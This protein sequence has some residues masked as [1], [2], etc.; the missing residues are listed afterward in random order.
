MGEILDSFVKILKETRLDKDPMGALL[1]E[2]ATYYSDDPHF[3]FLVERC[4]FL[5]ERFMTE[6]PLCTC[7]DCQTD[8][9][10][11]ERCPMRDL[12]HSNGRILH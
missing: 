10:H 7:E 9:L 5:I 12:L 1:I 8:P 2:I 6:M 3:E 11:D 4:E